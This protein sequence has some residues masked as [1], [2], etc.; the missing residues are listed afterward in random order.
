MDTLLLKPKSA[1]GRILVV[2]DIP[3]NCF[4]LQTIL[5]EEGYQVDVVNSGPAALAKIAE[6]PPGLVL[7]DVMMPDMSGYEVTQRIRGNPNLPFIPVVLVT[8]YDQPV[9]AD[10][11]GIGANG[12][13]RKPVDFDQLLK[14]VR[15]ILSPRD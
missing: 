1:I 7:L 6:D 15:S 12:F 10:G 2:D 8:G 4:L 5:E 14:Q 11:F 13:I 3:D 9:I